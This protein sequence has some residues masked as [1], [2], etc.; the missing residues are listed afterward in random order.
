MTT[1]ARAL[2]NH[3]FGGVSGYFEIMY[4]HPDKPGSITHSYQL[5]ADRPDW[6]KVQAMNAA[7]YNVHYGV[8][9]NSRRVPTNKRRTEETALM[10]PCL[11]VDFDFKSGDFAT[12][13]DVTNHVYDFAVCP[14]PTAVLSSG[15]GVHV[16]WRIKPVRITPENTPILK[17]TL[18]G[19]A[20]GLKSDPGVATLTGSLR[21]PNTI[22]TKKDRGGARCTLLDLLPGQY[23]LDTF[24]HYRQYA[25]PVARR[26]ERDLPRYRPATLSDY[27]QWY[28][29]TPIPEGQR[30]KELNNLA[31]HMHSN[32]Y[33]QSEAERV[34]LPKA[35]VDGLGERKSLRTI[36]SAFNA[37][38][39]TPSYLSKRTVSRILAGEASDR[40]RHA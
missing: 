25:Q 12:V 40:K 10:I 31:F 36:Q 35:L 6:S 15:G 16:L 17:Q 5:G 20:V 30:N 22:N 23:T 29:D 28:L 7:G 4:L 13:E 24:S 9:T 19:L 11:W 1:D 2:L 3:L 26:I 32:N 33:N 38:R 27:V 8:T 14:P 37:P 34:L 21:L 39:G 18:R